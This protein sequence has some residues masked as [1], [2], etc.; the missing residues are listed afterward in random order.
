MIIAPKPK[1][2]LLKLVKLAFGKRN[3]ALYREMI[4]AKDARTCIRLILRSLSNN[5][6]LDTKVIVTDITCNTVIDAALSE[7]DCVELI[8][9]SNIFSTV[10]ALED[11]KTYILIINNL[12]GL[13]D[14]EKYSELSSKNLHVIYDFAHKF[15]NFIPTTDDPNSNAYIVYSLWKMCEMGSGGVIVSSS[16][17]LKKLKVP[18]LRMKRSLKEEITYFLLSMIK[19]IAVS[20]T[21]SSFIVQKIL[22][23]TVLESYLAI[24]TSLSVESSM[25]RP[26]PIFDKWIFS[27]IDW[28]ERR[29][30]RIHHMSQML[31]KI[32]QFTSMLVNDVEEPAGYGFP[33]LVENKKEA[34]KFG[35]SQKVLMEPTIEKFSI[36]STNGQYAVKQYNILTLPAHEDMDIKCAERIAEKLSL[37]QNLETKQHLTLFK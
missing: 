37:G 20:I 1:L 11:D 13:K 16:E 34:I 6:S 32:K 25:L 14:F 18:A 31:K 7:C 21:P 29:E 2:N 24:D 8:D 9:E 3:D 5:S 23:G 26:L 10:K 19:T 4:L 36:D 22:S 15:P 12:L 30:A 27:R 17:N 33:L 28:V 35:L